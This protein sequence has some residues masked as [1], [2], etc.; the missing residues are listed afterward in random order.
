VWS[1]SLD[2]MNLLDTRNES[3]LGYTTRYRDFVIN[4][5]RYGITLRAS[6]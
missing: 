5:R 4:D 1:V 6:L 3:Y 2:G